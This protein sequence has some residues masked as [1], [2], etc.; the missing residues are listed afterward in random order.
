MLNMPAYLMSKRTMFNVAKKLGIDLVELLAIWAF[1]F[2]DVGLLE[3]NE[4]SEAISR[5]IRERIMYEVLTYYN[6]KGLENSSNRLGNLLFLVRDSV[7]TAEIVKENFEIRQLFGLN[8][9]NGSVCNLFRSTR[10][11]KEDM[12]EL[13][14]AIC[15][16]TSDGFHFGA[17]ACR[18]C[19]AFFRRTVADGRVYSCRGLSTCNVQWGDRCMCKA[20]RYQK[21]LDMGMRKTAVLKG[22][23]CPDYSPREVSSTPSTSYSPEIQQSH[24]R[25]L[26]Q[27]PFTL[28]PTTTPIL[29]KLL[30]NYEALK[31]VR[32]MVYSK[33]GEA[34]FD[35]VE[36]VP[37]AVP[38]DEVN[39]IQSKDVQL[40]LHF[41]VSSFPELNSLEG[42]QKKLLFKNY[43]F[44]SRIIEAAYESVAKGHEERFYLASGDFIQ[45]DRPLTEGLTEERA[46]K[47]KQSFRLFIPGDEIFR[48]TILSSMKYHRMDLVE[49]VATFFLCFFWDAGIQGQTVECEEKCRQFRDAVMRE[50]LQYYKEIGVPFPE[51]RLGNLIFLTR[52]AT[53]T[54][55]KCQESFDVAEILQLTV[56]SGTLYNLLSSFGHL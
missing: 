26:Q 37:R 25:S 14:C 36:R 51:V 39:E 52:D 7:K 4:T 24:E 6:S 1:C 8:T 10:M 29:H 2:W 46:E 33:D 27:T 13:I 5:R 20:C 49:L 23:T 28:N 12:N 21:C 34:L 38:R 41:L 30:G 18:A 32:K 31:S 54:M 48:K 11:P 19:A 9:I 22:S 55:H 50:L 17:T 16:H 3:Q 47:E 15:S 43:F 53:K 42:P 40:Q 44:L 56:L 35:N 45:C